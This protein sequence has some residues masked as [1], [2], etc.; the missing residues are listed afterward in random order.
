M[1]YWPVRKPL[2]TIIEPC[3]E[4][5]ILLQKG[6]KWLFAR[7]AVLHKKRKILM[8]GRAKIGILKKYRMKG[9]GKETII[10]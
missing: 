7:F 9:S 10:A 8:Q 3:A 5:S 6:P 4:L 2:A 1:R